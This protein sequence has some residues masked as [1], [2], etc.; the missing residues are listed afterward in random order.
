MAALVKSGGDN[1]L[2]GSSLVV[3]IICSGRVWGGGGGGGTHQ[4]LGWVA[5]R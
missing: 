3:T 5:Q 4:N 2:L 1:C